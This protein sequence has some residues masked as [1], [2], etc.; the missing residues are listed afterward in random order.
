MRARLTHGG[1]GRYDGAAKTKRREAFLA[2]LRRAAGDATRGAAP[3]ARAIIPT[4]AVPAREV[5]V[6]PP[7]RPPAA[8]AQQPRPELFRKEAIRHRLSSEDGRGVVRVSPPWAWALVCCVVTALVAALATS[9]VGKVEVT[10]RGRGILRP[11]AGVRALT[12]QVAG[13]VASV[14][15]SSGQEVRA[16]AAL[17]RIDAADLQGQILEADRQIE[18]LSRRLSAARQDPHY[19]EQL[20]SLRARARRGEEQIA[21]LRGS[22][23][24]LRRRVEVDAQLVKKGLLSELAAAEGRESLA[25]AERQLT[26]SRQSLDQAHQE[27]AS[28]ESRRQDD[29]GQLQKDLAAAQSHR[30]ALALLEKQSVVT[31]PE[32]GTVDAL[33][34]RV[35][36]V[37]R[38][39]QTIGKLIPA[40]SPLH[41]VAFL[42]ER[43]RAFVKPGDEVRLELDQLPHA[44][45]GTLSARIA[46]IGD[47]LASTAEIHDA[48]GDDHKLEA[49][50]YLVELEITDASAADAARVKLRTGALMDVRYTLRRQ[51]LITLVFNPLGRFFR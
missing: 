31:A 29:Q 47:D 18:A 11:L 26:A 25:Q 1:M 17:L 51:R 43:D 2:E 10:T 9:I 12:S 28:L 50:S 13:T 35:G 5:A 24:H 16:G 7:P 3:A 45:Y 34:V 14:E 15:A 32:G 4:A 46:R 42:A 44:E 41:V 22:V 27:L 33:T 38:A 19:V 37:V 21:S 8:P 23:E 49:P 40:G 39:G 48:L 36:E 30:D 6:R 20:D